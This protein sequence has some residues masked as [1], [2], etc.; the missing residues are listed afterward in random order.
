MRSMFVPLEFTSIKVEPL[1]DE[2][3]VIALDHDPIVDNVERELVMLIVDEVG[4]DGDVDW[5]LDP[6]GPLVQHFDVVLGAV[7]DPA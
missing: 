3:L 4:V 7:L 5:D 6:I 2:V 1:T